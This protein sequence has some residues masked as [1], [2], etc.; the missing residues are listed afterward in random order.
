MMKTMMFAMFLFAAGTNSAPTLDDDIM[1]EVIERNVDVFILEPECV[2]ATTNCT[3]CKDVV[4]RMKN[5]TGTLI[6]VIKDIDLIC[7]RI[8]GPA[9]KE[10]VNV[11]NVLQKDL[12]HLEKTNAT[13]LCKQWHYC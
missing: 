3:Q 9:A 11:T 7:K 12:E 10:C 5:E 13:T 6:T 4:N 1:Y 2:T 8:Y